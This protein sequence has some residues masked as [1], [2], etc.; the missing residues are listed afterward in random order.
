MKACCDTSPLIL[1][2]KVSHLWILGR[3][4]EEIF[5][6]PAVDKEWLRPGRHKTP[7][8]INVH[9]ISQ[10]FKSMV[11]RLSTEI[12]EAEAEAIALCRQ[13][14]IELLVI[15]DLKGRNQAAK[16][17]LRVIGTGGILIDAK[18]KGLIS[19]IK[20]VLD[21]LI[22][23]RYRID[24]DLYHSMLSKVDEDY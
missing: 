13:M 6:P 22:K 19:Q 14:N 1:L 20:P 5:I 15:D 21:E 18:R 3:I 24:E 16:L 8:F 2:D 17:G 4:F 23:S 12:D 7:E 11:R 10:D 9:Q